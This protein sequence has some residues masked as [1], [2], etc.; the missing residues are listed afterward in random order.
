MWEC[1]ICEGLVLSFYFCY[2]IVKTLHTAIVKTCNTLKLVMMHVLWHFLLLL[3]DS[4]FNGVCEFCLDV[5]TYIM[6]NECWSIVTIFL[7]AQGGDQR[8][9]PTNCHFL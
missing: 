9:M 8:L 7:Y 5:G 6:A 2:R 3:C 4:L 1:F